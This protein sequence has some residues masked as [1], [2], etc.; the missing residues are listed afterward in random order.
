MKELKLEVRKLERRETKQNICTICDCPMAYLESPCGTYIDNS[1]LLYGLCIET[2]LEGGSA[3]ECWTEYIEQ[4]QLGP[5]C[6]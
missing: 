3:A 4:V 6:P 1:M 2:S 5:C